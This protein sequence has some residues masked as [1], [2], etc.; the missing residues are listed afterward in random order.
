M[1][2]QSQFSCS[3]CGSEHEKQAFV[4]HAQK[5]KELAEKVRQACCG[6]NVFAYLFEFSPGSATQTPPAEVIAKEVA[7]SD[8]TI[9]LLGESV[10]GKFWTQAWIGFEIGVSKGI[11]IATDAV[12]YGSYN[13]KKV[14]VLQDIHQ[15]I[16]VT[17]PRLD[18]L[19]LFDFESAEGWTNYQG[20]VQFLTLTGNSL[21]VYK[22]GNNFREYV[23][24]ADVKCENE[25][26]ESKYETWIA[27]EDADKLRVP[28]TPIANAK[29]PFSAR[30][31]IECPS[32][33]KTVVRS[34]V[35]ML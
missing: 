1:S 16:E 32:C 21:E 15:G 8:L 26:C 34:F 9:V 30:C 13:S 23:M 10:S 18:A 6:V 14:I 3:V 31:T 25:S 11:D 17:V 28:F 24:N 19:F 35:K 7:K 20:L 27:I 5:D 33:D 2:S 29:P 4:S 22:A 12:R